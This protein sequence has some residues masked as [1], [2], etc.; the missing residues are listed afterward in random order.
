[1]NA[2]GNN[3]HFGDTATGFFEGAAMWGAL[4]G[5]SEYTGDN[6]YDGIIQQALL[7]PIGPNHDPMPSNQPMTKV[8][9][10][11]TQWH[12]AANPGIQGK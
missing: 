12:V 10:A 6:E 11:S 9:F 8:G 7:A 5:C 1:M 3:D 2:R 4:V